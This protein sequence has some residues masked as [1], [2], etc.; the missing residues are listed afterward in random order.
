DADALV[1]LTDWDDFRKLDLERLRYTLRYPII[2]DGRNLYD[3]EVMAER[4][5][6]YLSVGR[7]S[8]TQTAK[9]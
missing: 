3:P 8:S 4:G 6:T 1:L 5:F 9:I 2:V 7:S